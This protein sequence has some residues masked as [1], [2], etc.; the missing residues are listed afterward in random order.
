MTESV[1]NA[2][3]VYALSRDPILEKMAKKIFGDIVESVFI[4]TFHYSRNVTE[5]EI[6]RRAKSKL[7]TEEEDSIDLGDLDVIV[8][9]SSGKTVSFSAT[10]Y[11]SVCNVDLNNYKILQL[12][13]GV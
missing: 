10:E 11:G 5:D 12:D 7:Q 3:G 4:E 13:S 6:I 2:Y 1:M 8:V 9:F